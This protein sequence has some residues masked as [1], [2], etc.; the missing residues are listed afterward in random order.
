MGVELAAE[1]HLDRIKQ[2]AILLAAQKNDVAAL[3]A[4][5][6]K[7]NSLQIRYLLSRFHTENGEIPCDSDVIGRIVGLAERQADQL[8]IQD[9]LAVT[10]EEADNLSLPFML[11]ID[12]YVAGGSESVQVAE[13][14]VSENLRS[15]PPGLA[16][17][18]FALEDKG[19]CNSVKPNDQSPQSTQVSDPSPR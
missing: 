6:Y 16:E 13:R 19:L 14:I 4:T 2:T 5:C 17:Y 8:T 7:L 1:C 11:A 18:L 15:V 3:G 10:L 9:G 12:G